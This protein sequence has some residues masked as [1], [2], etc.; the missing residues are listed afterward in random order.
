MK[1]IV[2]ILVLLLIPAYVLAEE[3]EAAEGVWVKL[4]EGFEVF[5]PDQWEVLEI[6]D[7]MKENGV[8]Y[9]VASPDGER[10]CQFTSNMP[11]TYEPTHPTEVREWFADDVNY[12]IPR[13]A[14]FTIKDVNTGMTF[15]A[16]RYGGGKAMEAEP[17]TAEDTAVMK[18]IGNGK[19]D[20]K[21]HPILIQYNG[22][23]YAAS[24]TTKPIGREYFSHIR[25]N[26]FEGIF[27]IHFKNSLLSTE[28]KVDTGH[29]RAIE[30]AALASW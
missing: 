6:T 15:Q 2:L 13:G 26:E 14:V 8:F 19:L 25:E 29:Q 4:E 22:R 27:S 21:R 18:A 30:E 3:T 11:Q 24:M 23:V 9:A 7:E 28:N 12:L 5:V 20:W 17:L 1:W 10:V 16:S